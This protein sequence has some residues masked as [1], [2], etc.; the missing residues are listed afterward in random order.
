MNLLNKFLSTRF[1][2]CIFFNHISLG[3]ISKSQKIKNQQLRDFHERLQY[4][5]KIHLC[6]HLKPSGIYQKKLHTQ[7]IEQEHMQKHFDKISQKIKTHSTKTTQKNTWFKDINDFDLFFKKFINLLMIDGKRIKASR[8]LFN[9]LKILKKRIETNRDKNKQTETLFYNDKPL[10]DR[11][12]INIQELG[13][14]FILLR[15][16]YKAVENI[17]PYLEI[18]KV[19]VAG[20]TYLV[21]AVLS[22]KKQETLALK[23]IIE[24][25][26]KRQK[27]SKLD[28]STC[29]AD[30]I[31]DASRKLGQAR[32]KRDELHRL[33]QINRAY[34]RYRWW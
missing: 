30:E 3:N 23:W 15:I 25:A 2:G 26:K 11:E 4:N 27:N 10:L 21:P 33:A 19:R 24:S 6:V 29:L 32:Q 13:L 8:I 9:T 31:F 16:I 12:K 5:H 22:K 1:Q 20:S 28:F 14:N 7:T 34:I 18:R 17:T